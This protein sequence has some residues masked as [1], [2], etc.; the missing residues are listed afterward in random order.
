M[1]PETTKESYIFLPWILTFALVGALAVFSYY[2]GSYNP[3]E[4]EFIKVELLS[5]MRIHL[6][7]AI[8][9][10]K[11]AVMAI[12]D[13]ASESFAVR[14][15]KAADG[16]D[17]SRKEIEAII[18]KEKRP[19]EAEILNEFNI[20]WSQFRKL[21]ETILALATQNTNLKAQKISATQ[22]AQAMERFEQGLNRL[23]QRNTN[24][25]QGNEAAILSY[26]AL[27]AGLNIYMFS[28]SLILKR[29]TIKRWIKS[30]KASSLMTNRPGR[31]LILYA[32]LPIYVTVKI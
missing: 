26:E 32:A 2:R 15:R 3:F 31:L 25:H 21:D 16:V 22:G 6:L 24:H 11:N 19:Q 9:A 20:C 1:E 7:E 28:T 18:L 10:E 29:R 23:I 5:T 27:T 8:E 13:E 4:T 30:S 14:A 17:N 12:T